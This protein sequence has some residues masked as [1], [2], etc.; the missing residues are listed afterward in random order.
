MGPFAAGVTRAELLAA[1]GDDET[2]VL[3]Y[4]T[5]TVLVSG[6]PGAECVRVRDGR[7]VH[8]RIIFDRTP[9]DAARRAASDAAPQPGSAR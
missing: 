3:M 9:F 1:F 7:I 8:M 6:A 5:D 4:D 2:A